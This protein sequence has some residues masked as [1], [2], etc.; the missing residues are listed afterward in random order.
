VDI[1]G[2]SGTR[3]V[4]SRSLLILH[5]DELPMRVPFA[6]RRRMHFYGKKPLACSFE[7]FGPVASDEGAC[8]FTCNRMAP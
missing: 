5:D 4:A 2:S 1:L 3:G 7:A 6:T 8:Y